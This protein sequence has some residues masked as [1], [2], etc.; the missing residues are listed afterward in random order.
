MFEKL[1]LDLWP[2]TL[3]LK[4]ALPT[5]KAL[6]LISYFLKTDVYRKE[7]KNELEGKE[8]PDCH[9][10]T[11]DGINYLLEQVN[12]DIGKFLIAAGELLNAGWAKQHASIDAAFVKN[13]PK[14]LE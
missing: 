11:E 6:D 1:P 4:S 14:L 9:P 2:V 8:L 12:G 10:F 3:D 13:Q 7:N 5:E